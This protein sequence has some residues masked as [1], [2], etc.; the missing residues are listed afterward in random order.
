MK[1]CFKSLAKEK[2][3]RHQINGIESS[4]SVF[5]A[6]QLF[7]IITGRASKNLIQSQFIIQDI[8]L[9]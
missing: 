2:L 4:L 9:N 6:A 3:N 7:D 5:E 1:K 8:S